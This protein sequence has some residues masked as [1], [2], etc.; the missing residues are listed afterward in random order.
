[1]HR[2]PADSAE[3]SRLRDG[4]GIG[5]PASRLHTPRRGVSLNANE[6]SHSL[7]VTLI[8]AG[9]LVQNKNRPPLDARAGK[10]TGCRK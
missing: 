10:A 4:V 2:K 8:L 3:Q 7:E 6:N 5:F 9:R 1:M